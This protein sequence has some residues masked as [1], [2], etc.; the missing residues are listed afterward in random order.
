MIA[1]VPLCCLVLGTLL[2]LVSG[3]LWWL[4]A[5]WNS[6]RKYGRNSVGDSAENSVRNYVG[7]SAW[8]SVRNYGMNS[9]M[10]SAG[11]YDWNSAQTS[12]LRALFHV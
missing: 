10:N 8:H 3:H 12:S 5:A 6:D 11:N 2:S 4:C 9:D 1:S 7:N